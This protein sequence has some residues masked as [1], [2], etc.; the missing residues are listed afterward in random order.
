MNLILAIIGAVSLATSS[1]FTWGHVT[2]SVYSEALLGIRFVID[3]PYPL[4]PLLP[5]LL[6]DCDFMVRAAQIQNT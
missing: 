5:F 6:F 3:G 2:F 1:S 4:L